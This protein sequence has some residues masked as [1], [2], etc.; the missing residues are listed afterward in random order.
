MGVEAGEPV[1]LLLKSSMQKIN[2]DPKVSTKELQERGI[3]KG[4][5]VTI[6]CLQVSLEVYARITSTVSEIII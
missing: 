1:R 4:Y 3:F 6:I 2:K 5:L